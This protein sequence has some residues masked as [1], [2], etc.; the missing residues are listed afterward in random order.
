MVDDLRLRMLDDLLAAERNF[1]DR[2]EKRARALTGVLTELA[3]RLAGEKLEQM[4]QLDPSAPN[5][6][7]AEDWRNFFL[8]VSLTPQ[9][10]GWGK[11]NGNG[12]HAEVA[13]LRAKIAAL[14]RELVQ[15]RQASAY[16]RQ[17]EQDNP[18]IP[19]KPQKP[20]NG[21]LAGFVL[22]KIP[23]AFEHRWHVRA[24]MSK[25]DAELHLTRRGMVLKC[26]A[27]GLSVLVEIGRYVG[28]ATGS[29]YRSGA[30]RRVF[31]ALEESGL[32][33]RQTLSLQVTGNMPTRLALARLSA[34]GKQFCNALG[35]PVVESDWERL[36]RLHEGEKQEGHT[37]AVLLFASAARLR[38][39]TVEVLPEVTG[40]A[41]PDMVITRGEQRLYV[42]VETG[43][44]LHDANAKW[45]M[46]AELNGGRAALVARNVEERRVLVADCKHVAAHGHAVDIETLIAG[47]LVEVSQNDPL[48]AEEW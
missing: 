30:M 46:N 14:E 35:W 27:E 32:I 34:E 1:R 28:D 23:K 41:R 21:R 48:W 9:G 38:G 13:A 18:L 31:E 3:S 2:A 8:A 5:S 22:P 47:K 37:L 19:Q 4:R 7:K 44:R 6:W 29:Q 43:T 36:I 25:T 24:E 11:P 26:L 20:Q 15:T 42:E 17:V 10:E 12:H 45:R 33:V 39:W 16:Q 40:N